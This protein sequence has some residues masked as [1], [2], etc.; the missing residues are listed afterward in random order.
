MGAWTFVEPLL[1]DMIGGE[2]PIRYIGKSAR[3]SPAQGSASFHKEEH[4]QI[5]HSAFKGGESFDKAEAAA[6]TTQSR[7]PEA[8]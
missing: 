1:R 4:A 6:Q 3:P 8:S 5:V 7:A 2:L